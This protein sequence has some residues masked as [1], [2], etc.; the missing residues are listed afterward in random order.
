MARPVQ[1][2]TD[3][4]LSHFMR[5]NR[6]FKQAWADLAP[7]LRVRNKRAVNKRFF[8]LAWLSSLAYFHRHAAELASFLG[9]RHE[10]MVQ[11]AL[12][13]FERRT[14]V[15]ILESTVADVDE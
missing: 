9:V 6:A 12:E 13:D 4:E 1:T 15:S 7:Y 5:T 8:A 10:K 11:N 3:E 14:G 2:I